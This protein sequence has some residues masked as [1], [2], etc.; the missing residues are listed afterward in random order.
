MQHV[1]EISLDLNQHG[2]VSINAKQGD[3]NGRFIRIH[4]TENG[5]EFK[6]GDG[7]TAEFRA[8]KKDGK[9]I[10]NPA[11]IEEGG[12]ILACLTDQTLAVAG[13][14]RAD[15]SLKEGDDVVSTLNFI[16]YVEEA[17]IGKDIPSTNE[18]G[19]LTQATA[20]AAE[21]S[22]R[23]N[24][25][26]K[27]IEGMTTSASKVAA[28]GTPTAKLTTDGDHYNLAFG[29]VTGDKGAKGDK[30][31]TPTIEIAETVTGAP[32]DPAKVENVGTATDPKLKFTIPLGNQGPVSSVNGGTGD[33][34]IGGTNLL[35]G[36]HKEPTSVSVSQWNYVIHKIDSLSYYGVLPGDS[37]TLSFEVSDANYPVKA[38]IRFHESDGSL[39]IL[40]VDGNSVQN[41]KT[42]VSAKVPDNAVFMQ[43]L[44]NYNVNDALSMKICHEKLERGN[45]P[46]DW[47]PAPEDI[48]SRLAAI[49]ANG[50][51]AIGGRNFLKAST[52]VFMHPTWLNNITVE[53]YAIGDDPHTP[54]GK[55]VTIKVGNVSGNNAYGLSYGVSRSNNAYFTG[56]RVNGD[57]WTALMWAKCSAK[58]ELWSQQTMC[59]YWTVQKHC[60]IQYLTTE[61]QLLWGVYEVNNS[62]DGNVNPLNICVYFKD[63]QP[64]DTIYLSSYCIMHGDVL[65]I[66]SPAPE[67]YLGPFNAYSI[68]NMHRNIFRGKLLG[69]TFTDAQK[70]AIAAGTWDDLYL[71]DYWTINNRT[72]RIADF[73]YWLGKGDTFCTKHHIVVVPDDYLYTAQMHNTESGTYEAGAT[74]NTTAGGYYN[75]DMRTT[76]LARAKTLIE[77]AFGAGSIL[78]HRILL[79]NA[80]KDGYPSGGAWVDSE[81]D[82]MNEMMVY[83]AHHFAQRGNGTIVPY[84]YTTECT[85]LALFQV[86]PYY[87]LMPNRSAWYWLRD[88]VSATAFARF[89]GWGYSGCYDASAEGGVRPAVGIVGS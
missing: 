88:V 45:V 17:P 65:P 23:A 16:I 18:F 55:A 85:Q 30:G 63:L 13:E 49:E 71:G 5:T 2:Y 64:G 7:A 41:G 75:S 34:K 29:L 53:N 80:V 19:T 61:W 11:A 77:A 52:E 73:D 36:S 87:L 9:S 50:D 37:I 59:E 3:Q 26:A 51:V 70:A 84:N 42:F 58:R 28:G 12:T 4:L 39:T 43:A 22:N 83:G 48:E 62:S 14:V 54:S 66:W 57:T 60:G 40:V 67:D 76:N 56:E 82:L 86:I 89:L 35:K 10:I 25:A 72:W 24:N 44:A 21:A 27:L 15:I 1:Q 32:G 38:Q 8:V 74:A 78:N 81:V 68:T 6:P 79:T 20:D 33:V 69:S 31:D 47:S 46:T